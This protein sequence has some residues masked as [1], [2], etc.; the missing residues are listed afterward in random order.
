MTRFS[1]QR[2]DDGSW[3]VKASDDYG[4]GG[5]HSGETVAVASRAG[6]VKR[7]RLGAIAA[8]WNG[9][10]AVVYRVAAVDR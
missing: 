3:G 9:D 7:V 10:R 4:K 8:R 6:S 2:L 1:W 5:R